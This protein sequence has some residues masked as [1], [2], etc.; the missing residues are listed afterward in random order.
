MNSYNMH[1]ACL[2]NFLNIF[3]SCCLDIVRHV[4]LLVLLCLKLCPPITAVNVLDTTCVQEDLKLLL[5]I[6]I[7]AFTKPP[8]HL[9]MAIT[10]LCEEVY[11]PC[12][13][14]IPPA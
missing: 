10:K 8:P 6:Q 2:R 9:A 5:S 12:K 7:V 1:T 14:L 11:H 4:A 3:N 13:I